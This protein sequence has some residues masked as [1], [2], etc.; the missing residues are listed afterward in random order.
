VDECCDAAPRWVATTS[1][2]RIT[3]VLRPTP[4]VIKRLIDR[5]E[6]C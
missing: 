6:R 2:R 3:I 1:L 5:L 4:D